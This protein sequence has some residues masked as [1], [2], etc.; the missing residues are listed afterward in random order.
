MF[1]VQGRNEKDWTGM[2]EN[3]PNF[4]D[5][6]VVLLPGKKKAGVHYDAIKRMLIKEKAIAS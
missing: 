6:I 3:W 4:I 1:T 2:M 5:L